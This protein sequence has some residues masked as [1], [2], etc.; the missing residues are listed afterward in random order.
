MRARLALLRRQPIISIGLVAINVAV[1]LLCKNFGKLI[2]MGDLDPVRV[3]NYNEYGRISE[4]VKA[5]ATELITINMLGRAESLNASMAGAIT[6]WE[7]L[8]GN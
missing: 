2:Y 5:A 8:R 6:M 3:L 1:F 7:M 4:E